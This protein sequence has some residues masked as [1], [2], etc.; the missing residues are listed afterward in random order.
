MVLPG[1]APRQPPSRL[2]PPAASSP[3]PGGRKEEGLAP[4]FPLGRVVIP[5]NAQEALDRP[6][7][8]RALGRHENGDWGSLD[9]EDRE[10]N[11]LALNRGERLLSA[12][13][14]ASGTAFWIIT[15]W[16]RSVTT[17]LLR[18]DY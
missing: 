1:S 15:E 17:V 11:E 14:D 2:F 7:V 8:L 3:R 12:Y 4:L 6:S 10:T 13:E 18:Q 16:D 5:A 9:R